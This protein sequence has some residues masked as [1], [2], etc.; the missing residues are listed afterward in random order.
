[1]RPQQTRLI[2]IFISLASLGM[3]LGGI[4]LIAASE[5]RTNFSSIIPTGDNFASLPPQEK[6][7]F[8]NTTSTIKNLPYSFNYTEVRNI[9][10][11]VGAALAKPGTFQSYKA[12]YRANSLAE[13]SEGLGFLVDVAAEKKTL[14]VQLFDSDPIVSCASQAQQKSADWR[15]EKVWQ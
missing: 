4:V 11:N 15:C 12:I 13:N 6:G 7:V 2:I 14:F 9:E 1:M 8:S 5:G 10:E 3:L